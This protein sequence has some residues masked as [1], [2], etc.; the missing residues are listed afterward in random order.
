MEFWLVLLLLAAVGSYPGSCAP[1]RPN[2][3]TYANHTL[4]DSTGRTVMDLGPHGSDCR[5][6]GDGLLA[7]L[8]RDGVKH[9]LVRGMNHCVYMESSIDID[10]GQTMMSCFP[11]AD[12]HWYG[13]GEEIPQKWPLEKYAKLSHSM[14][15]QE[16]AN[17]GIQDP[18]WYN[19][20]GDLIY[21]HPGAPLFISINDPDVS[22]NQLCLISKVEAP[23]RRRPTGFTVK[24]TTC[25]FDNAKE[26]FQYAVKEFLGKP[27]GYPDETM[28][29]HPVWST[30]ARY[31]AA[32]NEPI[33]REF[34]KQ[35]IEHGFNNSQLEIDDAWETCYGS[36]KVDEGRFPNMKQL[37]ND[38]RAMGYRV[39]IWT[40]PFIQL[41]CTDTL[42]EAS[43]NGFLVKSEDGKTATHWWNGDASIVDFTNKAAADWF[44]K[45]H[46]DMARENGIDGFKFDAGE[47]SWNPQL[48]AFSIAH[49]KDEDYPNLGTKKYVETCA[50]FNDLTEV[51][52]AY[53]TQNLPIFVRMI[54]KDSRWG[55]DN[56]LKSLVTTLLQMNMVGYPLVLPDM[57]GGN[58]YNME[59]ATSELFIRWLQAN[60]FMPAIQFSLVPWDYNDG[61]KTT[62][63]S[64]KFTALHAEYTDVIMAAM[65]QSVVAGT[66][67]NPPI[68]WLDPT[69]EA[70]LKED[71]E[72]LLGESLLA[73]PVL[74]MGA[75]SRDVYLPFG[76][77]VDGNNGKKYTGPVTIK[78]YS[79]PLD[80][81]PWFYIEGSIADKSG[82]STSAAS[83]P[84]SHALSLTCA[85]ALALTVK[86]F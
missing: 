77:W 48:P 39:T 70:A 59:V 65:N 74:E 64:K 7:C 55:D 8:K 62:D 18:V 41:D 68:W 23:Y 25:N 46:Q 79:A 29:R 54:D 80:T 52:S 57:V 21:V 2:P 38:L 27:T 82:R 40:H 5:R 36:K 1:P 6:D 67:V 60:T 86:F 26:A 85:L 20:N 30:W 28:V 19:S 33:V 53:R 10:E 75:T 56:G 73:A 84:S 34:A 9:T 14:V 31:K 44:V 32:I 42:N 47:I 72:F 11:L 69:D 13:G 22:P 24:I 17:R 61:G 35:I 45:R 81:L 43:A 16:S 63:I 78:N 12:A 15:T 83:S 51:R 49:A 4:K 50:L 58:Q 71:S 66:P 76:K 37:T 3:L